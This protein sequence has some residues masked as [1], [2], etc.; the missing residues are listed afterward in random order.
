MGKFINTNEELIFIL[1]TAFDIKVIEEWL[2]DGLNK[3][4]FV[5]KYK[6]QKH[7]FGLQTSERIYEHIS[8]EISNYNFKVVLYY[9]ENIIHMS[10]ERTMMDR[11]VYDEDLCSFVK[12][13]FNIINEKCNDFE[14]GIDNIRKFFF[15]DIF[16]KF[17]LEKRQYSIF[18][19]W[20]CFKGNPLSIAMPKLQPDSLKYTSEFDSDFIYELSLNLEFR[21]MIDIAD[22]K[23]S[24]IHCLFAGKSPHKD[25]PVEEQ[26][27]LVEDSVKELLSRKSILIKDLSENI[28]DE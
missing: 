23:V 6:F 22:T 28:K 13:I 25:F 4:N 11:N 18:D 9:D 12:C 5:E 3:S 15:S 24:I 20:D 14:T 8:S 10:V 17:T 19:E 21:E 16:L 26:I 7:S 1:D 27:Y 2:L